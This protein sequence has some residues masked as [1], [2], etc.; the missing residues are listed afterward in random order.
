MTYELVALLI[1]ADE[2]CRLVYRASLTKCIDECKRLE[3][4]GYTCS[5][6]KI[7]KD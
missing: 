2:Y 3:A 7:T 1:K 6:H 5:I 4:K